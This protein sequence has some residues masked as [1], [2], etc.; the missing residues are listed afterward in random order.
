MPKENMYEIIP[1]SFSGMF[2]FEI[3]FFAKILML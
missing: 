2:R 1:E 3:V